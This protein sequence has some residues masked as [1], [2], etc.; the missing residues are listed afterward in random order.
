[1]VFV[2]ASEKV[3]RSLNKEPIWISGFGW[4]SGSPNLDTRSW[5]YLTYLENAAKMTYHQA[6]IKNPQK[7]IDFAEIDDTFSYKELQHLEALGIF[8]E[9]RVFAK[10]KE[11]A[12]HPEGEFPVNPSGGSLGMGYLYEA[13]G[14]MRLFVACL[15]L[16]GKAG[17]FQLKKADKAL[18]HSW[19]GLP[20]Q[21]TA[22]LIIERR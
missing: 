6:N 20:T 21:S 9:G 13:T 18:V 3:A 14:L 4:N 16:K 10:L 8:T 2:L 1:C 15:Q 17:E 11:G 7:E 5:L 12:F 19:R 22:C